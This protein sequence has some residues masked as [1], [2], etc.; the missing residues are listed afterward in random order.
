MKLCVKCN[1]SV[2][3]PLKANKK[4]HHSSLQKY[5]NDR[6][7]EEDS[8][9][10]ISIEAKDREQE[11]VQEMK[12]EPEREEDVVEVKTLITACTQ[13]EPPPKPMSVRQDQKVVLDSSHN[14]G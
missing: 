4:S 11:E 7:Q 8:I 3:F 5:S 9:G 2:K 14:G 1:R 13:T 10:E 12:I 6:Q